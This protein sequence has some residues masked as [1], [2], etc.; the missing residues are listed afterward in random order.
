MAP[1][2][3]RLDLTLIWWISVDIIPNHYR[4]LCHIYLSIFPWY[5]AYWKLIMTWKILQFAHVCLTYYILMET[6][7]VELR[8]DYVTLL[9]ISDCKMKYKVMII[10]TKLYFR[11]KFLVQLWIDL[12][13]EF[14]RLFF[15]I[16]QMQE[17]IDRHH[18]KKIKQDFT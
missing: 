15:T 14:W 6:E 17:F 7:I 8:K 9:H 2:W 5:F 4:N 3:V 13:E 10:S 11:N 1:F 12:Y 16:F 18:A